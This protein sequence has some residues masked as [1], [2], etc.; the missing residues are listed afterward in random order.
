MKDDDII[1]QIDKREEQ[2]K[3][4]QRLLKLI[5]A[6]GWNDIV[7]WLKEHVGKN[8]T[9]DVKHLSQILKDKGNKEMV[10][11]VLIGRIKLDVYQGF[12]NHYSKESMEKIEKKIENEIKDLTEKIKGEE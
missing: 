5:E 12:L 11:A 9:Q 2:L 1:K 3:V 8:R 10:Q 4:I 6:P 7:I